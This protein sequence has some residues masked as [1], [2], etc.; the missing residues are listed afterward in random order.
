MKTLLLQTEEV[1]KL[2]NYSIKTIKSYL[3]YINQYLEFSKKNNLKDKK[4][5]IKNFLLEKL[6]NGKSSQ[7]VNLAL[8]SIKFFYKEVLKDKENIDFKF[9]KTNKKLP[10]VLNK[11]E[12]NEILSKINNQKY[13]LAIAL[14]YAGGLRISEIQ[15]LKV[16][17][18]D[19]KELIIHIKNAKGKKDRITVFSE[20]LKI[21]F[22][23]LIAGKIG[24][25][26]VF[27]S[28]QGGKLTTR[29]FQAVFKK[30]LEK[31]EIKKEATFHSLR[32]SFAT[33]LLENGTDVRYIQELLGH[34]NIRTTQIYTK[35]MNPKLK[36]IKSPF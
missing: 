23:N 16:K 19:L 25:D 13:K 7:T 35:V 26:F 10:V 12:I 24:D 28:S 11:E 21:D 29:S 36:N 32:H 20:K 1:L 5:A 22:K 31:T 2:R 33:H 14:A 4:E 27:N 34:E 3:I 18:V 9:A 8:N 17:D 30:A 15:S 6:E